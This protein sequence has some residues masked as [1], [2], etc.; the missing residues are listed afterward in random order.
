MTYER[1]VASTIVRES[2]QAVVFSVLWNIMCFVM[3]KPVGS[4]Q[5][6]F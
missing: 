4:K 1:D 3:I 6:N 2:C 5:D